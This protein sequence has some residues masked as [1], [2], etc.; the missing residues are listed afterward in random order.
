MR[1]HGRSGARCGPCVSGRVCKERLWHCASK[2]AHLPSAPPPPQG[3]E[4]QWAAQA[5]QK[6]LQRGLGGGAL[7]LYMHACIAQLL[8]I[9]S[10]FLSCTLMPALIATA[11]S[12][13]ARLLNRAS[14]ITDF[15]AF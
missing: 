5:L 8:P 11:A 7:F 6:E 13:R 10:P 9:P 1:T 12:L 2:H 3:R 14:A 4:H 15:P